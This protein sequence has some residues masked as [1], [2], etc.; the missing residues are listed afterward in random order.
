MSRHEDQPRLRALGTECSIRPGNS[1]FTQANYN[2]RNHGNHCCVD[3][4]RM[5]FCGQVTEWGNPNP[6]FHLWSGDSL[7]A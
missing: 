4:F 6:S 2:S 5:V 3:R 7:T 1:W